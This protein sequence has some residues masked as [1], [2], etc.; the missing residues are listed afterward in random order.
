MIIKESWKFGYS[1]I[2]NFPLSERKWFSSVDN[3][4]N[5]SAKIDPNIQRNE[6]YYVIIKKNLIELT[7]YKSQGKDIIKKTIIL[8]KQ[9][10]IQ[11]ISIEQWQML[12]K[13]SSLNNKKIIKSLLSLH[14]G[15]N[16]CSLII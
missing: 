13:H 5:Y 1:E 12:N 14:A 7:E 8:T 2:L 16:K 11:N 9:N 15:I 3:C 10:I 6:N 4:S